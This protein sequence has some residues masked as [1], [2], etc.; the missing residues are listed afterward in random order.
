MSPARPAQRAHAARLQRLDPQPIFRPVSEHTR[1]V[2]PARVVAALTAA[3][4]VLG[5]VREIAFSYFFGIHP[6]F[7]SYR[8][9][10]MV[11]N[12]ARRLFG[13]GAMAS[14]FVPVFTEVLHK[15]SRDRAR[16]LAGSAFTLLGAGLC[17]LTLAIMIGLGIAHWLRPSPTLQLTIIMMPYMVLICLA[18]F[19]GGMLNSLNRFGVPAAA[20][21]LLN[22][23]L[24]AVLLVGGIVAGLERHTLVYV[25]AVGVLVAG[26][27]Q[28]GSQLIEMRR[29]DCWP[30]LNL[31]WRDPDLR[32]IL[33]LMGPMVVG[34]S[35][36]QLNVLADN[37]I[38]LYFVPGG[39]GPAVLGYA[40]MLYHLPQ[41]VF[42]IALATAIFPLLAARAAQQDHVGLARAFE[43]GMRVSMFI[44]LPASLGL[45]LLADPIVALVY[46]RR[47]G[48][49]GPEATGHVS[50][51]LIFYCLGLWAYSV[52]PTLARAFY[53]LQDARTPVR[54]GV[55]T[56][57]LNLV[58]SFVLV[59]PLAEGGIA[60]ATAV[61]SAIQVVWLAWAFRQRLPQVRWGAIA[62][63][64]AKTI[65]AVAVM[66]A[67][68]VWLQHSSLL[69]ETGNLL[70][71][72]VAIPAGAAIF[73]ATALALRCQEVS[74]LL[75][76]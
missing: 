33:A 74:E 30:K 34:L 56:V 3:S 68:L 26:V 62:T 5:L 18:G 55:T 10:F 42:G 70:R 2:G 66:T 15:D 6:L 25:V 31:L 64:V 58:L 44:A 17:A 47:G 27:L 61:A 24:I 69:T 57:A 53:A 63:G 76:R 11:P 67:F 65:A 13:E 52:Q 12:L 7:S 43:S 14:S 21:I 46:E 41:G 39:R 23:V 37:L 1:F 32:R 9:A 28:F 20:P 51:T 29:A 60:L 72:A 75:S 40:H 73:I 59:F 49:F 38:A 36:L 50:R 19:A 71:L 35:A 22:V 45:I 4:R 48:Q 8:V 54:V 16:V